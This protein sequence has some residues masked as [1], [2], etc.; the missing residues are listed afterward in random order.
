MSDVLNFFNV[1]PPRFESIAFMPDSQ[2]KLVMSGLTGTY[3]L[4]TAAT[5]GGWSSLVNLTNTTGAFEF[6]DDTTNS[7]VRFYRLKTFP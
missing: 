6:T 3:T 7:A 2:I 5:L 1:Q 4:Q